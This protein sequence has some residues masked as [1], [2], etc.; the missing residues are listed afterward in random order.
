M[1]ME[2]ALKSA[3]GLDDPFM[4]N[5]DVMPPFAD[6][7]RFAPIPE[8]FRMPSLD[9][10]DGQSDP[11]EWL[12]YYMS[13]MSL[14]NYKESTLCKLL[15]NFLRGSARSWFNAL[16][17]GTIRSWDDLRIQMSTAFLTSSKPITKSEHLIGM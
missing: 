13:I 15:P 3:N 12:K 5:K 10:Y 2:K 9:V 7:I 1:A 8:N 14:Y 11:K 17:E 6:H 16:A 4:L